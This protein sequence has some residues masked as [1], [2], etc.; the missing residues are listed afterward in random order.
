MESFV[1]RYMDVDKDYKILDVGSGDVNGTYRKLFFQWNYTGMDI[2]KGENVD[3]VMK[4][5]YTFPFKGETFDVVISGQALEH[6]RMFWI[7]AME[8]E[9]VLKP[10]GLICLIVPGASGVHRY[11]VDCWRM[12]PD[13]MDALCEWMEVTRLESYMKEYKGYADTVLIAR[14]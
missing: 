8:I 4:D 10:G 11:P 3:V 9:R 7:T 13:G 12:L 1:L 14:K 2:S 6:V 5:Q